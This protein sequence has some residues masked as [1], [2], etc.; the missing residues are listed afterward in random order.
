[1]D[2]ITSISKDHY[3]WKVKFSKKMIVW[4]GICL[5]FGSAVTF[6]DLITLI[7]DHNY[8]NGIPFGMMLMTSLWS[9]FY[10]L[11]SLRELK[12][13]KSYLKFQTELHENQLASSEREHYLNA[14]QHYENMAALLEKTK[15]EPYNQSWNSTAEL[16]MVHDDPGKSDEE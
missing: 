7:H 16:N 11:D 5:L 2:S 15:K 1:M 3:E 8:L 14:K 4:N 13:D 12:T 9:F 6:Y 10:L